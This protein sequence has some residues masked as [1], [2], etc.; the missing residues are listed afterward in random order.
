VTTNLIE[1]NERPTMPAAI[2]AAIVEIMA[3]VKRLARL[4]ENK[5]AHYA[6]ASIDSFL[7]AT[8]PLCAAAGLFIIADE[9]GLEI[10]QSPKADRE[11]TTTFLRLRWAF[12]IGHAS[13][14]LYGP[15]YRTVIV[16]GN[17]AQAFGS[18]QSYA[19]KQFMRGLFQIPTG[20]NDDPDGQPKA[21]LPPTQKHQNH[22]PPAGNDSP[23]RTRGYPAALEAVEQALDPEAL[24]DVCERIRDK[25]KLLNPQQ[26]NFLLEL[27]ASKLS[28]MATAQL[29]RIA[30][31]AQAEA[32]A[33][34]WSVCW[35][36]TEENRR[37]TAGAFETI[38]ESF[39]AMAS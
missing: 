32:A 38:K 10:T 19:L 9:A 34:W 26:K 30:T 3:G 36:L 11:G 12:W 5:F 35:V 1:T 21:E 33:G 24:L 28:G 22:R 8:G 7:E 4:D 39:E 15:I 14:A 13:G 23:L 18:A 6:Y 27:A 17:G 31:A 2:A 16:P 29:D 25:S 37:L 20:D